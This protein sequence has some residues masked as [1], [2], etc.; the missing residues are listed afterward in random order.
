MFKNKKNAFIAKNAQK[1]NRNAKLN[2]YILHLLN[3]ES[4]K[5]F[6]S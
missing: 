6:F 5:I 4:I 1:C 3:Q 2:K